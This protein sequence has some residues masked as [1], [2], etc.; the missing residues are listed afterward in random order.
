M[1]KPLFKNYTY[2]FDKNETKLLINFCNQAVKQMQTD[3]RFVLDIKSFNSIV[4]KLQTDSS[5][6]KLTKDEQKRLVGQLKEN[7]KYIES[8][9]AKSWFFKRWLLKTL[10]VQYNNIIS[11]HFSD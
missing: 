2:S 11:S 5:N 9:M 4:D 3:Q 7:K 6:V 8:Q 10:L 1:A